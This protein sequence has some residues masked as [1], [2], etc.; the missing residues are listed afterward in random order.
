MTP[1]YTERKRKADKDNKSGYFLTQDIYKEESESTKH[2]KIFWEEDHWGL[3]AWPF[4]PLIN[5]FGLFGINNQY[6]ECRY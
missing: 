1:E 4:Y 5:Y 2:R 3:M 6:V